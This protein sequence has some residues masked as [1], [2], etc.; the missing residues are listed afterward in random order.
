MQTGCR[1]QQPWPLWEHYTAQFVDGNSG[2]VIDHARAD[3]TTSEGQTYALFFAVVD[4]DR[5]RFDRILHWTEDN[6][7][8]GD[9][10]S[11][12]PAWSWGKTASG[13]WKVIDPNS[14]SDADLWLAYDLLEAGRLWH[15]PRLEQL[16]SVVADH[17]AHSEVALVQGVGTV[18]L[19]G[20]TGFHLS[21]GAYVLNPSYAPPQ[22]LAR[23][24]TAAPS[25]PWA[26]IQQSLPTILAQSSPQ[27]F[28]TDWVQAQPNRVT[29][30]PSPEGLTSGKKETTASGSY[31]A[32]RVYL[33]CGMADAG[34]EGVRQDLQA[35]S[36]MATYLA[37]NTVPPARVD[38][39]GNV[40]D[41]SG[42][43]GFSA[44]VLPYLIATGHGAEA[45]VQKNRMGAALNAANGLYG[46]TPMY[47]DQ[48]LALFATGWMEGRFKFARNGELRTS[49]S[50]K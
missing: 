41:P 23:L 32:I 43:V 36:G 2:R 6:L 34:T 42:P 47:Y 35:I 29:P 3:I 20:P 45:A 37:H 25:G 22:V 4:N 46:K 38:G 31:E 15:D 19:P 33:W 14:A 16:G 48:N 11:Y 21:S 27:G 12:L 30:S 24:A 18:L 17:I 50:P 1:A 7:A 44:A 8:G 10:A 28:A 39:N 9:L 40:V 5:P 26:S 49:W 13:E